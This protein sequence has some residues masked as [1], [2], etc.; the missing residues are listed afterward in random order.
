VPTP[1]Y[2]DGDLPR[3]FTLPL[4]PRPENIRA[5]TAPPQLTLDTV[6]AELMAPLSRSSSRDSEAPSVASSRDSFYSV[7]DAVTAAEANEHVS[8]LIDYDHLATIKASRTNHSRQVSEITITPGTPTPLPTRSENRRGSTNPSTPTLVSDTEDDID[9]PFLDAI[10]PPDAIRLRKLRPQA[11]T[12]SLSYDNSVPS[13]RAPDY[14]YASKSMSRR[15]AISTALI[16][17]CYSLLV[18]PP[19]HL[20]S[21]MLDI[22]ARIVRS[23]QGA[24]EGGLTVPGAWADE[25]DEWQEDDFGVRLDSMPSREASRSRSINSFG[26]ARERGF[27][28]ADSVASSDYDALIEGPILRRKASRRSIGSLD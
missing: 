20:V 5:I 4:R 11:S 10:T 7:D 13:L 17:K 8:D 24:R 23:M 2:A 3:T 15:R 26:G 19:S 21:L 27:S 22:A 9:L 28:R 1:S 25:E 14:L 18:G 12:S 6:D 16:Q